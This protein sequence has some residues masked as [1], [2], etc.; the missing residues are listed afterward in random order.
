MP[1]W[2]SLSF[3]FLSYF[4]L[5]AGGGAPLAAPRRSPAARGRGCAA[6]PRRSSAA[7]LMMLLD[8]VIDPVALQGEKW[9]LGQIYEY[10]YGGFYFGVTAANFAGWFLVGAASQWAFQALRRGA[11]V[12][13]GPWRASTP[14]FVWGVFARV[15]RRVRVQPRRDDLTSAISR[16]PLASAAVI[17]V[18]L[19]ALA[20]A[21]APGGRPRGARGGWRDPRL[22]RDGAEAARAARPRRAAANGIEV[23]RDR[24]RAR[25]RGR[26]ARGAAPAR[27]RGR[28]SSY[29][30]GSRGRSRPTCPSTAWVTADALHRARGGGRRRWRCRTGCCGWPGRQACRVVSG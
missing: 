19:G 13:R 30:R 14:R 9:F 15:R 25:A 23:L 1:F 8:V 17:A 18:T 3:V 6:A 22:R 20:W 16:S 27:G 2:D 29:P 4:S 10:P 24:R 21:P 5:V 28:R 7:S 11:A 26:R 12:V